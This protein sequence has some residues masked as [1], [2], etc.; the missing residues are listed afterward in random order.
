MEIQVTH[1]SVSPLC[2]LVC[3][4]ILYMYSDHLGGNA[5]G[6]WQGGRGNNYQTDTSTH[7]K[8]SFSRQAIA[9]SDA[10]TTTTRE[11]TGIWTVVKHI[12]KLM[13]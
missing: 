3:I 7:L 8:M 6:S 11:F 5:Y 2:V 12:Q 10:P 1:S 4:L 13:Q 9:V